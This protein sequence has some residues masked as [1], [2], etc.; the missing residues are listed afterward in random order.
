M[1]DG[2]IA[3]MVL[4]PA[5]LKSTPLV[6]R[7]AKMSVGIVAACWD[8]TAEA[9]GASFQQ[10]AKTIKAVTIRPSRERGKAII[11]KICH[12][13]APSIRAA[14]ST[15]LLTVPLVMRAPLGATGRGS[16]AVDATSEIP[17]R[18]YLVPLDQAAVR[19][20]GTAVTI[21]SWLLMLHF[22]LDAGPILSDS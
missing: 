16:G 21:L 4:T 11:Q 20:S 22:S 12:K 14:S 6:L 13:K 17:D 3:R 9:K 7:D 5:E 1:T 2:A 10:K 15:S 18:D 19:R 8:I